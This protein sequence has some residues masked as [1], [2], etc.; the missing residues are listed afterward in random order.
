[1]AAQFRRRRLMCKLG[2]SRQRLLISVLHTVVS[3][4]ILFAHCSW[5]DTAALFWYGIGAIGS[6]RS[7]VKS[8][9]E[10]GILKY[11]CWSYLVRYV[12]VRRGLPQCYAV[13]P[14]VRL[15]VKLVRLETLRRV[16]FDRPSLVLTGS[17]L[18][19]QQQHYNIR[20]FTGSRAVGLLFSSR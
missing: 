15:R 8:L 18:S 2:A 14:D 11:V 9:L 3:R 12:C 16:P 10:V 6:E 7:A 20:L 1:M 4:P 13:A 19:Q 17:A 5:H